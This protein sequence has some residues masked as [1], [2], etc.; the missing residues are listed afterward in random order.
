MLHFPW[1]H[2]FSEVRFLH[3]DKCN[4][5]KKVTIPMVALFPRMSQWLARVPINIRGRHCQGTGVSALPLSDFNIPEGTSRSRAPFKWLRELLG[6]GYGEVCWPHR[7]RWTNGVKGGRDPICITFIGRC[8]CRRPNGVRF[9]A[10]LFWQWH[11][12]RHSFLPRHFTLAQL[13]FYL[14]ER[15]VSLGCIIT[16]DTSLSRNTISANAKSMEKFC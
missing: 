10:P 1:R 4:I 2:I 11:R 12:K 8:R 9:V 3:V 14:S 13:K 15:S 16:K 7:R 5:F 6:R